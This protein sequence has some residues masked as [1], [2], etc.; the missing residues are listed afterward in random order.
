MS[1]A[2]ETW[3][4]ALAE[5]W[6][7]LQRPVGGGRAIFPPREFAPADG[8][9][10]EWFTASGKGTVYSVTWIYRRPPQA[11]YNV[12]LVDLEEG[13]RMMSMVEGV[14]ESSLAIGLPVEARIGGGEKEPRLYFVPQGGA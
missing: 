11:A 1:G 13:P 3:Q 2:I 9:E 8:G 12:V 10:L 14:D 6:M 7:T 5:G 4:G